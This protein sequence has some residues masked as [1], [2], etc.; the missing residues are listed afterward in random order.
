MGLTAHPPTRHVYTKITVDGPASSVPQKASLLCT[1]AGL[2]FLFLIG[3]AV[4]KPRYLELDFFSFNGTVAQARDVPAPSPRPRVDNYC[5]P[6]RRNVSGEETTR[7]PPP[8]GVPLDCEGVPLDYTRPPFA[9][10]PDCPNVFIF[11]KSGSG[12]G[13]RLSALAIVLSSAMPSRAAVV[14]ARPILNETLDGY[15]PEDFAGLFGVRRFTLL[16]EGAKQTWLTTGLTRWGQLSVGDSSGGTD[17]VASRARTSCGKVYFAR[18]ACT[19]AYCMESSSSGHAYENARPVLR[20]LYAAGTHESFSLV[21]FAPSLRAVPRQLTVAW[22]FRN[23]DVRLYDSADMFSRIH[24]SIVAA[25]GAIPAAHYAFIRHVDPHPGR[26]F[27]FLWAPNGKRRLTLR[28]TRTVRIHLSL[29]PV[30]RVVSAPPLTFID[31]KLSTAL[32]FAHL[33]AAD[34]LVQV[35][36]MEGRL[37]SDVA[38]SNNVTLSP[39][40]A[41]GLVF[42]VCCWTCG[43]PITGDYLGDDG[44]C[45]CTSSTILS[46]LGR[47]VSTR[48]PKKSLLGIRVHSMSTG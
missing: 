28:L 27:D 39:C 21:A 20:R 32:T 8:H 42:F 43:Q 38:S 29:L 6:L 7:W 33:A 11:D 35:R 10:L 26:G 17:A 23:G 40:Y 4:Y 3:V 48:R 22:H 2:A 36:R 45:A 19:D 9:P 41:A 16:D 34:I 46:P 13:H 47:S 25:L 15:M 14:I 44:K 1:S 30:P 37:S 18:D 31:P 24:A 5:L 12:V